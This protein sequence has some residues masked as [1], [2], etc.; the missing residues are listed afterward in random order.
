MADKAFVFYLEYEQQLSRLS[1]EQ[2]GKLIRAII[3]YKKTDEVSETGDALVDLSFDFLKIDLDKQA[4]KY[5]ARAEA[6]R[7]GGSK[8]KQTEANESNGKQ[9]EANESK[10]PTKKEK[11]NEKEN[12]NNNTRFARPSVED[13][14]EYCRERHNN[15]DAQTFVDFYTSKNWR[16]GTSPMK[17]WRACVRTWEKR[18]ATNNRFTAGIIQS[19]YSTWREEDLIAN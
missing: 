7:I 1:D 11:E 19:D 12:I 14:A 5:K 17:D 16:V 18:K 9:T 6:G 3:Q 4:E 8:R 13:V 15:V 2:L 10:T